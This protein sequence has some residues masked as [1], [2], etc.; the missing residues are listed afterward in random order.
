MVPQQQPLAVLL[1]PDASCCACVLAVLAGL[2]QARCLYCF[3]C[4]IGDHCNKADRTHVV[5]IHTSYGILSSV[6]FAA[7]TAALTL[8]SNCK[9]P[10]RQDS[11]SFFAAAA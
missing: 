7:A 1:L 8:L 5:L 3:L 11:I 10:L 6:W 4:H 9:G 2:L